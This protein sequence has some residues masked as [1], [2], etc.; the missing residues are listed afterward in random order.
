MP[1]TPGQAF[2]SLPSGL[3]EAD[4]PTG[5]LLDYTPPD[6]RWQAP[7]AST[8]ENIY[9]N[10]VRAHPDLLRDYNQRLARPMGTTDALPMMEGGYPQSMS[11][12]G[13]QHWSA[14]GQDEGRNLNQPVGLWGDPN[15]NPYIAYGGLGP[16]GQA[17]G[18][19]YGADVTTD[20]TGQQ[21]T[22][23]TVQVPTTTTWTDPDTGQVHTYAGEPVTRTIQVPVTNPTEP[24]VPTSTATTPPSLT[25]IGTTTT[26]V[27][28][29][30]TTPVDTTPVDTTPVDT[31]PE[32]PSYP[33]G[34]TSGSAWHMDERN[35]FGFY[36]TMQNMAGGLP[37][38]G[39]KTWNFAQGKWI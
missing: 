19:E 4:Y 3:T 36:W 29:I 21:Y 15:R 5:S 10:Y 35:Q 30:V 23:Q 22:T 12:Y 20:E 28:P 24:T 1:I 27:D 26:G 9:E 6:V 31:T 34:H 7:L 13:L 16:L 32:E 37:G 18:S 38:N 8:G 11:N 14:L 2:L 25:P 39:P 17:V 33:F